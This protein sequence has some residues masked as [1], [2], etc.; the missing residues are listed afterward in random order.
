VI[1]DYPIDFTTLTLTF[2]GERTAYFYDTSSSTTPYQT[3][4]TSASW[5]QAL[6]R[7]TVRQ[8][9]L[10]ETYASYDPDSGEPIGDPV[11]VRPEYSFVLY[12]NI[13]EPHRP[14]LHIKLWN[15]QEYDP[16][17][18]DPIGPDP[19]PVVGSWSVDPPYGWEGAPPSS[20]DLLISS[21]SLYLISRFALEGINKS[22]MTSGMYGYDSAFPLYPYKDPNEFPRTSP[23]G[24]PDPIPD[25]SF[26]ASRI[27]AQVFEPLDGSPQ[28]PE[29]Q[30]ITLGSY[31]Y[32][33][34]LSFS[35][36]GNLDYKYP[37]VPNQWYIF[38]YTSY[39]EVAGANAYGTRA[40]LDGTLDPLAGNND[41]FG[42]DIMWRR[43]VSGAISSLPGSDQLKIKSYNAY[44]EGARDV[45]VHIYGKQQ[46]SL[47]LLQG[48]CQTYGPLVLDPT[49]WTPR[50]YRS[51]D[52]GMG[53]L[54]MGC[55][56]PDTGSFSPHG[57]IGMQ[58]GGDGGGSFSL[59]YPTSD[60]ATDY[61]PGGWYDWDAEA[62]D[63]SGSFEDIGDEYGASPQLRGHHNYTGSATF[64]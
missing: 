58:I 31:Q 26:S 61:P 12:C 14:L 45:F 40:Q 21:A 35:S 39:S 36:I 24:P 52:S 64:S 42:V 11:F 56:D 48:K 49:I 4:T 57:N 34:A 59:V 19:R 55:T 9:S 54:A 10:S 7:I 28:K 37:S 23:T 43:F 3:L 1:T 33:K 53:I 13:R 5:S 15:E 16:E 41:R 25:S 38:G 22:P 29:I 20:G 32:P 46:L 18:G 30:R 8:W 62:L 17:T 6:T 47:P 63:P 27:Q 2:D 50:H 60:P 44:C 51:F